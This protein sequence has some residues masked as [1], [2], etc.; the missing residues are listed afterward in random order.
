MSG[1]RPVDLDLAMIAVEA[2]R[3]LN[4]SHSAD[5][6]LLNGERVVADV[7]A[8]RRYGYSPHVLAAVDRAIAAARAASA[9]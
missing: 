3:I 4:A 1:K 6:Y 8:G 7:L 2:V 5:G 9:P